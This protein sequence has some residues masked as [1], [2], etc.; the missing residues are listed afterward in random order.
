MIRWRTNMQ[1]FL[2]PLPFPSIPLIKIKPYEIF[3]NQNV[4]ATIVATAITITDRKNNDSIARVFNLCCC[5]ISWEKYSSQF[6]T[7]ENRVS[8]K[9]DVGSVGGIGKGGV[10][11]SGGGSN[12]GGGG[13]GVRAPRGLESSGHALCS[14][15]MHP[16][17]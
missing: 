3:W 15:A 4:I 17:V 8:V 6:Y 9:G 7:A 14:I 16:F 5:L 2:P 11:S 13:G 1:L 10:G 12:S